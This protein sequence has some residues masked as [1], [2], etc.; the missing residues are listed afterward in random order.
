MTR[1]WGAHQAVHF[2]RNLVSLSP[3][4]V[5]PRWLPQ[6]PLQAEAIVFFLHMEPAPTHSGCSR[7][8]GLHP[9]PPG[10]VAADKHRQTG[11]ARTKCDWVCV[12][13]RLVGISDFRAG[14]P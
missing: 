14:V 9:P 1:E 5:R 6:L 4:C 12:C 8:R 13:D 10:P 2:L 7:A 3:R 11:K